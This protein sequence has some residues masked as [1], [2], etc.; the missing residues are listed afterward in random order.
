MTAVRIKETLTLSLSMDEV[1]E[2][3]KKHLFE[4][5]VL[6]YVPTAVTIDDDGIVIV[7]DKKL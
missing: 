7:A 2:L 5:H 1:I 4:K 6:D 3:V